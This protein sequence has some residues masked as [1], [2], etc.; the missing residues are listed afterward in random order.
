MKEYIENKYPAKYIC[1]MG[2]PYYYEKIFEY[3]GVEYTVQYSSGYTAFRSESAKKQHERNQKRIDYEIEH[4]S[5]K[6]DYDKA[7]PGLGI[8]YFFN[9]IEDAY[10]ESK[11]A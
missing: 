4:K 3:R 1:T 9:L 8:D 7:E 11:E 10:Y 5:V 6:E 2:T